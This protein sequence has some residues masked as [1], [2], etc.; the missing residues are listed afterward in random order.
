MR[1]GTRPSQHPADAALLVGC[2]AG[3]PLVQGIRAGHHRVE[4]LVRVLG[5]V[6][7]VTA[8]VLGD[9]G[10]QQHSREGVL[11]RGLV[12]SPRSS[13]TVQAISLSLVHER[14]L[15][16][17]DPTLAQRWSMTQVLECT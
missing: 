3:V 6:V 16:L 10:P 8:Q 5:H 7:G 15:R 14:R 9:E 17:S 12:R 4:Q 1:C 11:G 2:A 13:T